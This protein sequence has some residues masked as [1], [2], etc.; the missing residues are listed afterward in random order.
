MVS[1]HG[2]LGEMLTGAGFLDKRRSTAAVTGSPASQVAP[3]LDYSS[4]NALEA[5]LVANG[6]TQAT[7]NS[8]SINDLIYAYRLKKD[9]GGIG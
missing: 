7:L 5:Y 3:P 8:M 4:R 2:Q 6:Y 1:A 9:A